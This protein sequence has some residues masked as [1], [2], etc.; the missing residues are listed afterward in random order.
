MSLS[1]IPEDLQ[2]PM[3]FGYAHGSARGAVASR[4]GLL[5]QVMGGTLL[6]SDVAELGPAAQA[7]LL[8]VLD[9]RAFLRVGG[10]AEVP[11]D[12][13]LVASTSHD[14]GPEVTA[15]RFRA[16]LHLRISAFDLRVPSLREH[17]DDILP[18]AVGLLRKHAEALQ[19]S[20]CGRGAFRQRIGS[21]GLRS[22]HA[23]G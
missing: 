9:H 16:A 12:F 1:I 7:G 21:A 17:P 13:R 5:D 4:T 2:A 19:R 11:I 8:H 10:K 15:R 20:P 3:L 14:L 22:A 6:L 23:S 18:L